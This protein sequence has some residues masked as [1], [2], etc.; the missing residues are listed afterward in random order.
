MRHV[1]LQVRSVYTRLKSQF[2]Q[3]RKRVEP[4]ELA[5]AD[6]ASDS[7]A[8]SVANSLT[9]SLTNGQLQHTAEQVVQ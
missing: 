2:D 4:A 6:R 5:L 8:N 1:L 9:G 3:E 7:V